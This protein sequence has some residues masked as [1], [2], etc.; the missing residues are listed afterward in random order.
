MS[1]AQRKEETY[2]L[3][4]ALTW[5]EGERI[6]I[7]DGEAFMLATPVRVHQEANGELF[8]QIWQYLRDKKCRVYHPPFAVRLF[9]KNND[10]PENV[11]TLVE[12]DIAIVCD[13][14]KLDELGCK[15]APDFIA[16]ILSPSTQ[17]H[18]RL[19]KLNLY[20]RAGVREYWIVDLAGRVVQKYILEEGRF[21]LKEIGLPDDK[22]KVGILEDC[23]IELS[24]IFPAESGK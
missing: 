23:E 5:D 17:R 6:E 13:H 20:E 19:T 8:G 16:E 4:D 22:L 15:G 24:L 7:I 2:T 3:A 12:P 9:E 21:V 18:D 11:M 1:N 10:K 14:S